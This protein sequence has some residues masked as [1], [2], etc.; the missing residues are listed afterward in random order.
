MRVVKENQD[1]R[2]AKEQG[3]HGMEEIT[4]RMFMKK[5]AVMVGGVLGAPVLVG[6]GARSGVARGEV[7]AFP[8]TRFSLSDAAKP[9]VLVAYG[10]MHG[11]TG[12]VAE[13]VSRALCDAGMRAEV[14]RVETVNR[15]SDYN[16]VIVGSAVRGGR[17]LPEAVDFVQSFRDVL[18]ERPVAYFLTC[19]A[20]YQDIPETRR[21]ASEYMATVLEA[22]PKVVPGDVGLFAGVLD[23]TQY[24]F[25]MRMVMK[26]KMEKLRV[27][28]GDHRDW[29]RIR[30]WAEG[31]VPVICDERIPVAAVSR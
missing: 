10:S 23:Y 21:T 5:G 11:S 12:G 9:R 26:R 3:G 2:E 25:V 8:E 13:A 29:N 18:S 7:P 6:L 19:L 28:E 31:L 14:R 27:P 30:A 15:V 24:N 4:R 22:V 17:W 20:L 16:A 1:T